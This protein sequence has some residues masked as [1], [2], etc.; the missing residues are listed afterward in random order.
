MDRLEISLLGRFDV[1][2]DG[3]P[4]TRFRSDTVRAMLAYLAMRGGTPIR[5][6]SLAGLFWPNQPEDVA[7]QNLRQALS[8]LRKTIGDRDRQADP[9]FLHITRQDVRLNPD[10]SFRLDV[11]SF[12]DLLAACARHRHRRP[13]ACPDCA[14]R[15]Q[16]AAVLYRGDLLAGF[17]LP[18]APFEEW[19]VVER[20]AL[21]R[22]ALDVLGGLPG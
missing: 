18:S 12:A 8:Q 14:Q 2:L 9:P 6:E 19:M 21:H 17:S 3:H 15:L 10:S 22:Q 20:E 13:D 5:R 4:L 1:R 7:R 16:Q 11:T